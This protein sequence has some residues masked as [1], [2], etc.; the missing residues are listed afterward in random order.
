LAGCNVDIAPEPDL[1]EVEAPGPDPAEVGN[2]V[3]VYSE[4]S[5]IVPDTT[6]RDWNGG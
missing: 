2:P 6:E 3:A 4:Y 5:I 1:A